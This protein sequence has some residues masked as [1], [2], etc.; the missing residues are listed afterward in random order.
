MKNENILDNTIS[1]IETNV[2]EVTQSF[3][4]VS[5]EN[6]NQ[7]INRDLYFKALKSICPYKKWK[8]EFEQSSKETMNKLVDKENLQK[9]INEII[10]RN[11]KTMQEKLTINE[12]EDTYAD[13]HLK[14][15]LEEKFQTDPRFIE[16]YIGDRI[17]IGK[18][19]TNIREGFVVGG[20]L[21]VAGIAIHEII[22]NFGLQV[23]IDEAMSFVHNSIVAHITAE[24][25]HWIVQ[26][27]GENVSREFLEHIAGF[28]SG[29]G[30]IFV[31]WKLSRYYNLYKKLSG[32]NEIIEKWRLN[33]KD[34]VINKLNQ[35][36]NTA[37]ENAFDFTQNA[38]NERLTSLEILEE[39]CYSLQKKILE[40]HNFAV[41]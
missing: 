35:F 18:E 11:I 12:P 39:H 29:I 13:K 38:Y 8:N 37:K 15:L 9:N 30:A 21:A 41:S 34:C 16:R 36:V 32:N 17:N 33:T 28:L 25:M 2:N 7:Y 22:E 3:I 1:E 26:E 14:E 4:I 5:E 40:S 10:I 31:I 20:Y 24:L 19:L 23:L 27:V 6:I